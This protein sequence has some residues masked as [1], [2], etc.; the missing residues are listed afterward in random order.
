[1][2]LSKRE[3]EE[4]AEKFNISISTFYNWEKTKPYLIEIIILGLQKEKELNNQESNEN[5]ILKKVMERMES[6]EKDIKELKEK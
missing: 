4:L 6:L 1:M 2:K 5:N 3:K